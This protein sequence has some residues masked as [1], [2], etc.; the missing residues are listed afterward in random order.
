MRRSTWLP[1]G[2]LL[3]TA[4]MLALVLWRP[5]LAHNDE[6]HI[7]WA[8]RAHDLP[9]LIAA[10]I[11]LD[12]QPPLH[13]LLLWLIQQVP[14]FRTVPMLYFA[15]LFLAFPF[16][17]IMFRLAYD[18]GGLRAGMFALLLVVFNPL[19]LSM[20][21]FLRAYGLTLM[22][23]ALTLW[24]AV[25]A[26]RRPQPAQALA[27]GLSGLLLFFTF[28][29]GAFLVLATALYL[30]RRPRAR[31]RWIAVLLGVGIPGLAAAVWSALAL[32]QAVAIV[33]RHQGSPGIHPGP[34]E[35]ALN[36]WLTLWNGWAVD[37]RWA[38]GVGALLA[39]GFAAMVWS[40]RLQLLQIRF[41]LLTFGIP[42]LGFLIGGWRYN[43]FA[44]RYAVVAVPSLLLG[45][46]WMAAYAPRRRR[47][48]FFGLS[49]LMGMIG[50]SRVMVAYAYLPENNPWYAE[51]AVELKEHAAPGDVVIIQAPWHYQALLMHG[52]DL[53]WQLFDLNEEDRWRAALVQR[54]VVWF[55]GVPAYRGNWAPVEAALAGWI[56][57]EIRS[58]PS[59][60]DAV[61][62]RY[63]PPAEAPEWREISARFE[64]GLVLEAVALDHEGSH[65]ILRVG[66]RIQALQRIPQSYT[67][68][69]HLLD[70]EGRWIA[71]SDAE[72]PI[73]TSA[74]KPG[75][76]IALWR[77]LE[78]PSWLPA[79]VYRVT[80][81]WYP[82]GSNGWPRLRTLEGA[83][84]AVL[85]ELFLR[86]R[87]ILVD[88]PGSWR[89]GD[90]QVEAVAVDR[91]TP[92]RQA[93]PDIFPDPERPD[94]LRVSLI[95]ALTGWERPF[96]AVAVEGEAGLHALMRMA[97]PFPADYPAGSTVR[98][99]YEG[100]LPPQNGTHS[101]RVGCSGGG[102]RIPAWTLS[103]RRWSW[104]YSW[105]LWNRM[106]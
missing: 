34:L 19:V 1:I 47:A 105:I 15:G 23:S 43:F 59:P 46:A 6:A 91:L 9:G 35:M 69:V 94:R 67:L 16:Y 38:L 72:P 63:V 75:E 37:A 52:P 21:L 83:D 78:I 80:A 10:E 95:A 81:G 84:V 55:L 104:N 57:E 28:Y 56:R 58:W 103:R 13:P 20:M 50:L 66:L 32:R 60:A 62:I 68:F 7:V 102:I 99:V 86:P 100:E 65:G 71:G 96:P 4:W 106:P 31:A 30:L 70:P 24:L 82:T 22:G 29:Y 41:W 11:R 25:R 17:P 88:R 8:I 61:L 98:W 74:L 79:G 53:P 3:L 85:G 42:F 54:P 97:P 87:P 51:V 18:M 26:D 2:L 101:L 90:L 64:N 14:L 49:G 12:G 33:I 73:S 27:W 5:T 77:A 44:A 36:L 40:A 92:Y 76:P 93:G 45:I 39:V 89:C 48:V